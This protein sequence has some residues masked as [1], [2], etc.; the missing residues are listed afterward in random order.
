MKRIRAYFD[1]NFHRLF[2]G[3]RCI[4][5]ILSENVFDYNDLV[6]VNGAS[7]SEK[8]VRCLG[9]DWYLMMEELEFVEL[10]IK[11]QNEKNIKNTGATA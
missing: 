5:I 9:K 11:R 10:H 2:Y 6:V 7:E 8:N 3:N 1:R 4:K